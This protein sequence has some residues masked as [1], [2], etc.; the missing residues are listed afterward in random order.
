MLRVAIILACLVALLLGLIAWSGGA[1]EKRADFTFINR[2]DIGTLDPNR[3]SWLQDIRIGYGLWEGLYTLEPQ[4]LKAIPGTADHIE[5]SPDKRVYVFHI[6]S[7]ARWSNGDVVKADDFV[8]AWRRM[9]EEP[10]DYTYLFHNIVGAKKYQEDFA[11]GRK[12]DFSD[13][14]I[15]VQEGG[16]LRGELMHPVA[17]F[18]D[19]CAFPAFWPLHEKSM[20]PFWQAA[21]HSY[22]K[23]FTRPP[24][25]VS[26][27]PYRL[28]EWNFKR[29]IRLEASAYY[30]DRAN[31]RS[32]S[33]E[34]LNADDPTW[35]FL[36][37][38]TGSID[39]LADATGPIGADLYAQKRKDM[40]V[41]PAFGSYFYTVNCL[42]KL[43]NGKSN[44]F[45]DKRVR[46][47][48][49]L[50]IDRRGIVQTITRLGEPVAT[51]YIPPGVFAGY[52]SPAGL[53]YNLTKARQLLAEAGYPGGAGFPKVSILFNNEAHHADVAQYVRRQWLENLGV[54]VAMEGQEVKV[55][56][57]RLHGKD[58][59][60]ARASWFGDYNDPSTFTDKY[61]ADSEN[62]DSGWVNERYDRLCD[63]AAV[64]VNQEKRLR[65][66]EEA[67]AI[68][69]E[70]QPIIP[71]YHYM[72]AYLYRDNVTGLFM[73]PRNTVL[74]K[75][76]GLKR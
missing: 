25:L 63:Q 11:A 66:F 34:I 69:L 61:R 35:G 70:E 72:N 39:W 4:T 64:E 60:L 30:W 65:L 23:R 9:L 6:R 5:I 53:G 68:L 59:T 48:F 41:F 14:A 26:N 71:L 37:Y 22:D 75:Y 32:Q 17:Y 51:T 62:N 7:D 1:G 31:V 28:A 57:Q 15:T 45:A 13:V 27:G 3:M 10:G 33:I 46:Q 55:F 24:F 2:G 47:A 44:P 42:P 76:V 74:L 12:P 36:R 29:N 8:F 56:R 43:G 49:S 67:E 38:D 16:L 52:H 73:N 58:Y 20:Q 54:D 18:P 40:H 19:L 50:A 21:T